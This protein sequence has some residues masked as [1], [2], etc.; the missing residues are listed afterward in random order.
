MRWAKA[1]HDFA[2][3]RAAS[4][5]RYQAVAFKD[6]YGVDFDRITDR[7]ARDL[8]Q[9]IFRNYLDRRC[10]AE[11]LAER[12]DRGD[13]TEPDAR[14]IGKQILRDNALELFRQL[15]KKLWKEKGRLPGGG[16]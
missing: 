6:L 2:N 1:K 9:R 7:E 15:R 11:V 16:A 5:Y 3:A 4:F 12:V 14:R 13:L 8:N 10:L